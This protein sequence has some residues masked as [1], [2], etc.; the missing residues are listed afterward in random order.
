MIKDF[1]KYIE[2]TMKA[3]TKKVMQGDDAVPLATAIAI[4]V[5][6]SDIASK[7]MAQM[8][9]NLNKIGWACNI[10][11]SILQHSLKDIKKGDPV[12]VGMAARLSIEV[13]D[14]VIDNFEAWVKAR[15]E[16]EKRAA[17]EKKECKS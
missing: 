1:K 14:Q 4:A 3:N 7:Q 2:S 10:A 17:E 16:N 5:E 12:P 6:A 9:L 11:G 8:T 15:Y 13:V